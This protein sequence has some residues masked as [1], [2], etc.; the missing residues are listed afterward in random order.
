[1]NTCTER[2]EGVSGGCSKQHGGAALGEDGRAVSLIGR[3]GVD[4][5]GGPDKLLA[6]VR[7]EGTAHNGQWELEPSDRDTDRWAPF[8][9]SEI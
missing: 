4:G 5:V 7:K 6:R 1:M 2:K 3:R 8:N 9:R